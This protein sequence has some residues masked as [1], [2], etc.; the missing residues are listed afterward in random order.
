MKISAALTGQR[1]GSGARHSDLR[2][3][4]RLNGWTD[5]NLDV[6][7][8]WVNADVVPAADLTT[9]DPAFAGNDCNAL[10]EYYVP[11]V[12][13]APPSCKSPF[14]VTTEV[15]ALAPDR[16]TDQLA[17]TLTTQSVERGLTVVSIFLTAR[18]VPT[19]STMGND[20][21]ASMVTEPTANIRQLH[22]P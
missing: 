16:V 6:I 11:Q 3:I 4:G 9:L 22:S 13:T 10:T 1:K 14:T 21:L 19:T 7:Y 12:Y 2:H 15:M 18:A 20:G 17:P 8:A 5:E